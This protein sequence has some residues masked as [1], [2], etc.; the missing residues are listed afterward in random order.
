MRPRNGYVRQTVIGKNE[1]TA[2]RRV[3]MNLHSAANCPQWF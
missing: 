2:Q 3:L 1:I